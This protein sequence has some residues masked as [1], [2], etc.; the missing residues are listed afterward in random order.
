M[1]VHSA[2]AQVEL[3]HLSEAQKRAYVIADNRL[4]LD[5]GWDEDLLTEELKA[6]EGLDFN[7]ALTGFDL[8][9]LN[10]LLEDETSL[11]PEERRATHLDV[12]VPRVG[13]LCLASV[14]NGAEPWEPT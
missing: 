9:E 1:H 4:A 11:P 2:H 8:D 14:L 7:L 6:L 13:D 5:A 12:L 3:T 10:A